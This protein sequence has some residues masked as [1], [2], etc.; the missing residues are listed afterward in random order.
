MPSVRT[1]IELFDQ[2]IPDLPGVGLALLDV[3]RAGMRNVPSERP[4]AAWVRDTLAAI[5]VA[6]LGVATTSVFAVSQ[7]ALDDDSPTVNWSS[8]TES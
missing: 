3:L 1:L 4:T 6:E 5:P 7:R 2:P 8:P